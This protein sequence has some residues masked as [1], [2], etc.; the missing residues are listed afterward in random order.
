MTHAYSELGKFIKVYCPAAKTMPFA[1]QL[2]D[3]HLCDVFLQHKS[4]LPAKVACAKIVIIVD[5]SSDVAG[6][7]SVNHVVLLL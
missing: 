1:K 4:A 3:K 6:K 2:R 7:P 5:E